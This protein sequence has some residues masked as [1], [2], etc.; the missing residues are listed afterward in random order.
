MCWLLGKFLGSLVHFNFFFPKRQILKDHRTAAPAGLEN[1]LRAT[2]GFVIFIVSLSSVQV[3]W[4]YNGV[5]YLI[6][7]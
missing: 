7:D 6:R 3:F 4:W 5:Q 2:I 1:P